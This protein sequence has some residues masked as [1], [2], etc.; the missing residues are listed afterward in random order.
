MVGEALTSLEVWSPNSTPIDIEALPP[1]QASIHGP[2]AGAE[3]CQTNGKERQED[4]Y[5]R[6]L[7]LWRIGRQRNPD[8]VHGS[9]GS[10]YWR[11]QTGKQKDSSYSRNRVL[12]KGDRLQ[13]RSRETSDRG[14]N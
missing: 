5:P 4:V 11:P 10:Y 6:V 13:R 1:K 8:L 2:C 12:C 7:P 14:G 9:E 3:H